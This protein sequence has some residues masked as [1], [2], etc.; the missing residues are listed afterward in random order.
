MWNLE[1]G[2][3]RVRALYMR[4]IKSATLLAN[5]TIEESRGY[6]LLSYILEGGDTSI[7]HEGS[8]TVN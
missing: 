2:M 4:L 6:P 5:M 7:S 8:N 1:M 3:D